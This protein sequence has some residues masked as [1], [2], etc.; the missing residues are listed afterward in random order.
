MSINSI[1]NKHLTAYGEA[2]RVQQNKTSNKSRKYNRTI[3]GECLSI[4]APEVIAARAENVRL[5]TKLRATYMVASGEA[6]TKK[7]VS[8]K[9]EKAT[10]ASFGSRV[11]KF[12]EAI[13]KFF[14]QIFRFFNNNKTKLKRALTEIRS[15]LH[16]IGKLA[17]FPTIKVPDL[18]TIKKPLE[19]IARSGENP[20]LK[21]AKSV[22]KDTKGLSKVSTKELKTKSELD[23]YFKEI[24]SYAGRYVKAED[25]VRADKRSFEASL[26]KVKNAKRNDKDNYS[27]DNEKYYQEKLKTL[28][29]ILGNFQKGYG[30]L[31]KA[32]GAINKVKTGDAKKTAKAASGNNK[33]NTKKASTAKTVTAQVVD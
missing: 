18:E 22:K 29:I 9:T 28:G 31:Y 7:E 27:K 13:K 2:F 23:S 32:L 20:V 15:K 10:K 26:K 25:K 17:P 14:V 30:A 33:G 19:N 6:A 5:R 11:K 8:D 24:T 4:V 21:N 16:A 1:V 3:V 12:I